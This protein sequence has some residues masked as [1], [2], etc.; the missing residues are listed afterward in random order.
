[1]APAAEMPALVWS[2][3]LGGSSKPKRFPL[4][5]EVR[6]PRQSS[7]NESADLPESL[8]RAKSPY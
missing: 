7:E 4:S 6:S 8:Q 2:S 1:M 5:L 3:E